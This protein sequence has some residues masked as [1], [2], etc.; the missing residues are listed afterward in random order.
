MR[1][2]LLILAILVALGGCMAIEGG[3]SPAYADDGGGDE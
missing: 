2:F 3:A 1:K